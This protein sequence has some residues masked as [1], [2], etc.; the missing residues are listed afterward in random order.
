MLPYHESDSILIA[1][2]P[3]KISRLKETSIESRREP[4]IVSKKKKKKKQNVL[5]H[6]LPES[7]A[8]MLRISLLQL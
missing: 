6:T 8:V 3:L 1:F 2:I 5:I 4:S 7:I